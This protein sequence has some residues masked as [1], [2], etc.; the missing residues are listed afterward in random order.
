MSYFIS[1]Q[2][3]RL[4]CLTG[5]QTDFPPLEARIAHMYLLVYR[6]RLLLLNITAYVISCYRT[7]QH[8]ISSHLHQAQ[9][10]RDIETPETDSGLGQL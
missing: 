6:F 5:E 4:L 1:E 8:V 7:P 10:Q 3:E 2:S 9:G